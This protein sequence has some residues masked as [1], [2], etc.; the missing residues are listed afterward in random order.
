MTSCQSLAS[1]I[2]SR[3]GDID[4]P[5][6]VPSENNKTLSELESLLLDDV[7]GL[8]E[9]LEKANHSLGAAVNL[10]DRVVANTSQQASA[11]SNDHAAFYVRN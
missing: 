6:E 9:V 1:Q 5:A 8:Q 3:V 11:S 4:L 7:Q 10:K 2:E